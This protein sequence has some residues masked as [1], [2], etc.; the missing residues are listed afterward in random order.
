MKFSS[1]QALFL[2]TI[3]SLFIIGEQQNSCI[4][5]CNIASPELFR[6]DDKP[7]SIIIDTDIGSF[8]DDPA[9]F[10]VVHQL[11]KNNSIDILATVGSTKYDGIAVAI[12]VMNTYF[13]RPDIPVGVTKDPNAYSDEPGSQNWTEYIKTHLPHRINS[14]EEAEDAVLVYRRVL[15]SAPLY[16]VTILQIGHYTNLA[17]LLNSKPDH[18][19]KM[20][21]KKLVQAKVK[22]VI[23]L[24]GQFPNGTEWNIEKDTKSAQIFAKYWPTNVTFVGTEIGTFDCFNKYVNATF[25]TVKT[26][27]VGLNAYFF[28]NYVDFGPGCFDAIASLVAT[29]QTCGLYCGVLGN[30]V[31]N[32]NGSNNWLYNNSKQMFL[33]ELNDN[34]P[35]TIID[36][37]NQF[38]P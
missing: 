29:R 27:P 16:S 22:Q 25:G 11:A 35:N 8:P 26:N 32:D 5:K 12:D 3:V 36:K 1:E 24:S 15:A 7:I 38:L 4:P 14:N 6:N 23:A 18:L 20:N 21:G 34:V 30:I 10:S 33:E 17:N 9:A 13:G 19:S 37:V 2:V 31:V 28:L